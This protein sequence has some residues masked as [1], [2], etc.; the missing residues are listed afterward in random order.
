MCTRQRSRRDLTLWRRESRPLLRYKGAVTEETP[1][2]QRRAN[3]RRIDDL[4]LRVSH[5]E[6]KLDQNTETTEQIRDMLIT[7]RTTTRLIKWAGALG[8]A[9]AA[10]YA[11]ADALMR[12]H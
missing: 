2:P 7:A 4:S 3:D 9:V 12:H 6:Q 8:A 5:I 10:I 11:A 1:W